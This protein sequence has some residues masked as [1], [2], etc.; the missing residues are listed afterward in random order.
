M[1]KA[2]TLPLG[3]LLRRADRHLVWRLHAACFGAQRPGVYPDVALAEVCDPAE[4]VV[5]HD[6]V[7]DTFHVTEPELLVLAGLAR[8]V[9]AR[10]VFELGTADGRTT[11][12]LAANLEPGGEVFTLNLPLE[13]DPGHWQGVPLGA[14]FLGTAEEARITQLIG[15]SRTFDFSP[16]AGRCQLVFIDADHAEESVWSDTHTALGMIDRG[17][18]VIAWHDALRYGVQR[19]LPRVRPASWACRSTWWPGRTWRSP[20][21]RT[22]EQSVP[23]TGR[24][25][26]RGPGPLPPGLTHEAD[27]SPAQAPAPQC[28]VDRPAPSAARGLRP[29]LAP[30]AAV[31]AHQ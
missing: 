24:W 26:R 7:A 1:A 13:D 23:K 5:L 10:T 2:A 28:C 16:Y 12:N 19:A 9:R 29:G 30:L 6:L 4:P 8:R 3:C 15:D 31:V 21:S 14:R 18:G 25:R 22:G 27:R 17:M 11:R 20:A